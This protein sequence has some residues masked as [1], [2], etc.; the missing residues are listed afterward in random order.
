MKFVV[1]TN[2]VFSAVL[3]TEGKIGDLLMNSQGVF[4]FHSCDTLRTELA[5]HKTKLI[6]LSGMNEAQVDQSIY[7][8]TSQIIFTNE[9]L[10]PFDC[11]LKSAN[12]VRETDMN[13]IAFLAL[14]ELLGA[15]IWTGDKRL[16]K[17]LLKKGFHDFTTT[18]ELFQLRSL[19][20]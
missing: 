17:G 2:L 8:I 18:E 13:D 6:E 3:N 9:A 16:L 14:T 19:L 15:K 12:L 10:I 4:E 20:E 1:D 11:W 7:Q 5:E